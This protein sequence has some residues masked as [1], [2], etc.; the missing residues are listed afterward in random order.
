LYFCCEKREHCSLQISNDGYHTDCINKNNDYDK[1]S[2]LIFL[3]K[4]EE[5]DGDYYN[6][7]V[8]SEGN[9]S[10]ISCKILEIEKICFNDD[11]VD[12]IYINCHGNVLCGCDF[13]YE[14][15]DCEALHIF[16]IIDDV[17]IEEKFQEYYNRINI[18]VENCGSS[19]IQDII[20]YYDFHGIE[21]SKAA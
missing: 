16:N 8:I 2:F 11:Y 5:K 17:N 21:E 7:R 6:D 15:Q 10:N 14:T 20:F 12:N 18:L 19:N 3:S 13:S 1:L 9:G 4:R